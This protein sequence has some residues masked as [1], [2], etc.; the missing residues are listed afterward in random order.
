VS[1]CVTHMP[2]L[3][4]QLV[5]PVTNNG[6]KEGMTA[7]CEAEAEGRGEVFV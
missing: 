7:G 6:R 3:M 2:V 1:T 4:F 5:E